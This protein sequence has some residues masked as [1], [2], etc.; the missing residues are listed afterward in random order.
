MLT[1]AR[2]EPSKFLDQWYDEVQSECQKPGQALVVFKKFCHS[3]C[4]S[5]T[6]MSLTEPNP[7]SLIYTLRSNSTHGPSGWHNLVA[8]PSESPVLSLPKMTDTVPELNILTQL[9]SQENYFVTKKG[10]IHCIG[11]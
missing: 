11:R 6:L 8:E 9:P 4:E 7:E 1:I 10:H 3:L 2:F 5:V